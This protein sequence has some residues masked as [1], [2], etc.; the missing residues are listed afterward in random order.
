MPD[1]AHEHV[2]A[3][4]VDSGRA[5]AFEAAP[6][7]EEHL[8]A[9]IGA[10]AALDEARYAQTV[11]IINRLSM[12]PATSGIIEAGDQLIAGV[13]NWMRREA[14]RDPWVNIW[15]RDCVRQGEV[16][17]S[18]A[19]QYLSL[20]AAVAVRAQVSFEDFPVPIDKAG[21]TMLP[22]VGRIRPL[23]DT[24]DMARINSRMADGRPLIMG[25]GGSP[26][27]MDWLWYMQTDERRTAP[28][29]LDD[30][31]PS[32]S[33]GLHDRVS[34]RNTIFDEEKGKWVETIGRAWEYL[35]ANQPSYAKLLRNQPL[36]IVPVESLGVLPE[37]YLRSPALGILPLPFDTDERRLATSMVECFEL[38]MLR[39]LHSIVGLYKPGTSVQF[40]EPS[41]AFAVSFPT[42]LGNA[43]AAETRLA[44]LRDAITQ[45]Y[46]HVLETS[47]GAHS[48][49]NRREEKWHAF[50]SPEHELPFLG[51]ELAL[52]R[53]R[54]QI[55]SADRLTDAGRV[56]F[57]GLGNLV[58]QI[59]PAYEALQRP[60][61]YHASIE[62]DL[63][64]KQHELAQVTG[65]DHYIG[66]RLRNV[67]LNPSE[68]N[69]AAK[70]YLNGQLP[71]QEP[72]TMSVA[73]DATGEIA[74]I[75]IAEDR[76]K[77]FLSCAYEPTYQRVM[78]PNATPQQSTLRFRPHTMDYTESWATYA[79]HAWQSQ[80]PAR[81]ALLHYPE[82]VRA[83]YDSAVRNG[84]QDADPLAIAAWLHDLPL[85]LPFGN[86]KI[87]MDARNK[88]RIIG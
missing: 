58:D 19:R 18:E 88:G 63:L 52:D 57:G 84:Q 66:W 7:D 71:R 28:L 80:I 25:V 20:A 61:S 54:R 73:T 29:V 85:P 70:A 35:E 39:T 69:A 27:H 2:A 60:D 59:G 33:R 51:E 24:N 41:E 8:A 74:S 22:G 6:A 9:R 56:V 40:Y 82:I 34:P 17:A 38:G 13:P 64:R 3:L 36:K 45:D 1:I 46:A 23:G 76:L 75:N 79:L 72:F 42:L 12:H 30:L 53:R 62:G 83:V 44:F 15:A 37:Q 87:Y 47:F 81:R 50:I 55:F 67:V 65:L 68:V 31:T 14:L 86:E 78:Q 26:T 5:F 77:N 4:A 11:T 21:T 32:R 48:L 16:V 10:I 49:N 43:Y